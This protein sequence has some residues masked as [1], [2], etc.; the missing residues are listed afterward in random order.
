MSNTLESIVREYSKALEE[1]H[2][3]AYLFLDF[4][5]SLIS[6]KWT[7]QFPEDF[8]HCSTTDKEEY[9]RTKGF[10]YR[11][12]IQCLNSIDHLYICNPDYK[13]S[14]YWRREQEAKGLNGEELQRANQLRC[15]N[16]IA[17]ADNIK[18]W[19]I[20]NIGFG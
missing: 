1:R 15:L 14:D 12:Y 20:D 9:A 3:N 19:V 11:A 8:I 10:A 18:L 7:E 4:V 13:V 16:D 5:E 17:N 2:L 6:T